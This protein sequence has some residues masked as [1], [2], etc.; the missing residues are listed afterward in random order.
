MK[1]YTKE[2]LRGLYADCGAV[3][4]L[5]DG[6]SGTV[7]D[8][9]DHEKLKA[10]DKL[11]VVTHQDLIDEKTLRLFGVWCARQVQNLITDERSLKAIDVAERYAKGEATKEDLLAAERAASAAKRF[12]ASTAELAARS[13]ASGAARLAAADA[14][15]V[16]A[17]NSAAAAARE[18][19]RATSEPVVQAVQIKKL[20]EMVG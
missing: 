14:A 7:I 18:A 2:H 12:A 4:D 13:A 6:W 10:Q 5:P 11:C 19:V 3:D 1:T 17:F 15:L 9:L 8:I 20:R 16:A